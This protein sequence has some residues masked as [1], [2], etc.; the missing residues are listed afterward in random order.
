MSLH[1]E[2][3][4]SGP[5]LML[6][7]GWGMHGGVWHGVAQTLA[8]HFRVHLVDLPGMGDSPACEPYTLPRLAQQVAAA[9]PPQAAVCGWSFGGQ[10]AMRLALDF[11][12]KVARLVLVG[13]TPR[14]VNGADWQH[15]IDGGVFCE[16]AAQVAQDYHATMERFLGLQ[17]FG[18]ESARGLLRELRQRF[19]A[20]PVPAPQVLQ[21]ALAVLLETD[22]RRQFPSL[23]LPMQLIHGE[24]DTLAPS[25]AARW[26]AE[27]APQA[28]LN[29]IP[30]ASHAP[31][32]SHPAAFAEAL[33]EFLGQPQYAR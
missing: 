16:F 24:R 4:G 19:A 15:G 7:H 11:P 22:L 8:Q 12:E 27:A 5:D 1:V 18:G 10:V 26:M 20:R 31:F 21:Q 2:R 14:F 30:R 32:I 13:S 29:L 28:S 33:L 6:L 25:A 3:L 17:A 9:T 23:T